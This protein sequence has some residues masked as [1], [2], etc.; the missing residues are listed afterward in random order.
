MSSVIHSQ[1]IEQ[2]M[3]PVLTL[4]QMFENQEFG[5]ITKIQKQ[6]IKSIKH[7]CNQINS[8]L[9]NSPQKILVT[10]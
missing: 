5:K 2:H 10:A 6:K 9:Q 8:V 3:L 1:E 4:V 7:Y